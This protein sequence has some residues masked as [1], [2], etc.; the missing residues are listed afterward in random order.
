MRLQCGAERRMCC[1]KVQCS[2]TA[3]DW[4]S[5]FHIVHRIGRSKVRCRRQGV[6]VF[7][8]RTSYELAIFLPCRA[9]AARSFARFLNRPSRD[10][11]LMGAVCLHAAGFSWTLDL[12]GNEL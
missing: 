8:T 7:P 4:G 3:S 2:A 10:K 9:I 1:G 6:S 11:S 12:I 5:A